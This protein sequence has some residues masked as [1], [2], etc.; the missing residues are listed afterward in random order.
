MTNNYVAAA[1]IAIALAIVI[2]LY[3][4]LL[5]TEYFDPFNAAES[6]AQTAININ[7]ARGVPLPRA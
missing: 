7:P 2:F 5:T 4:R 1:L 3:W 6:E